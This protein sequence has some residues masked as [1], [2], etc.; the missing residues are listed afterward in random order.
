MQREIDTLQSQ[1][2]YLSNEDESKAGLMQKIN[3]EL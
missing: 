2:Q 1:I 3:R